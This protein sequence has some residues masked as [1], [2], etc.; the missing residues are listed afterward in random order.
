M[1]QDERPTKTLPLEQRAQV[2]IS[3]L[4]AAQGRA[5][6]FVNSSISPSKLLGLLHL[7]GRSKV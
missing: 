2:S 6:V 4:R 1:S 3:A 7:R 5:E